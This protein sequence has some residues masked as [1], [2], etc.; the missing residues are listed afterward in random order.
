MLR[1]GPPVL[2]ADPKEIIHTAPSHALIRT[3]GDPERPDSRPLSSQRFWR[4]YKGKGGGT[5]R[6]ASPGQRLPQWPLQTPERVVADRRGQETLRQGQNRGPTVLG[7]REFEH[8]DSPGHQWS[9]TSARAE[10]LERRRRSR[11]EKC[12]GGAQRLVSD[13]DPGCSCVSW[14]V[15]RPTPQS[16]PRDPDLPLPAPGAAPTCVRLLHGAVAAAAPSRVWRGGR[17]ARAPRSL[18][19]GREWEG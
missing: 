10:T 12:G 1:P 6:M 2:E 4:R 19:P 3:E 7:V 18:I 8:P 15:G 9:R 5:G 17:G 16:L 13:P 11:G 14:P